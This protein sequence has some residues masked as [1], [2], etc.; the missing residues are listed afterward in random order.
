MDGFFA[1]R[2]G[3]TSNIGAWLDPW[4]TNLL[5]LFCLTALLMVKAAPFWLV[6]L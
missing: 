1:R 3:V 6:F 4:P 5:M 2:W